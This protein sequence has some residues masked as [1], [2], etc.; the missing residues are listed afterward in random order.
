MFEG[1]ITPIVT[2]FHRDAQESINYEATK[3]LID[4]LIE[5]G[6][7]GIF[8]LG[9]NGEFHVIDEEEK[10]AFAKRVIEIVNKRVPVFVGTGC[11]STRE[12]IRL[13]KK[14]E[15]LGAD[16]LSVITP[17]FL[18]PTN[19][20]LYA[21]YKAVAESV[22]LPIVLYNIPKATGCPLDP[23]LVNELADIEN[24]KA[25]K[26]SSGEEERIQ[27]YAKIA[28]EKDFKLL[29]GS[30]SKI[31]YAYELGASGAVAGT[32]NV[33]TDTLVALDRALRNKEQESAEKL[34]KDIDVLRGVLKLGTVP[35]AMKRAVELAGIAEVGPARMPV[36]ELSK[37]DDEKI[38]EMLRYY[39]LAK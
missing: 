32:S 26:D 17:Y 30:D 14:M 28:K 19:A 18:K 1:I 27:A 5:H 9:S 13:S 33:I 12:T 29:I 25:I 3:Q 7:K 11:C 37:E 15:E 34:Q 8:I 24:I 10:V 22:N 23:E 2:P 31:S 35:S 36:E 4:H 39:G 16:A 38:I 21:H 20:N 6:V